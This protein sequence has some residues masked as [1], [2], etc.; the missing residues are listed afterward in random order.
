MSIRMRL[1][2]VVTCLSTVSISNA[3]C[4]QAHCLCKSNTSGPFKMAV[5]DAGSGQ[6]QTA[7]SS[8][9]GYATGYEPAPRCQQSGGGGSYSSDDLS[10][11]IWHEGAVV[12]Q[13]DNFESDQVIYERIVAKQNGARQQAI[14][15]A[16]ATRVANEVRSYYVIHTLCQ[17]GHPIRQHL[18]WVCNHEHATD[19]L[20]GCAKAGN[21]DCVRNTFHNYQKHDPNV[22]NIA[23]CYNATDLIA[24]L[25]SDCGYDTWAPHPPVIHESHPREK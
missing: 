21:I 18:A 15:D 8:N 12:W 16:G 20:N 3:Q 6:C 13:G 1:I 17:E 22:Q 10:W 14:K 4:G 23:A 7:C 2:I 5:P 11:A 9:G 24:I 25:R 19:I